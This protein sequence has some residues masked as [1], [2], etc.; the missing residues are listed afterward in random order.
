MQ[1]RVLMD[2][3]RRR[4]DRAMGRQDMMMGPRMM[5]RMPMPYPQMPYPQMSQNYM[6]DEKNPYGS[7]GGYVDSMHS[8]DGR[9]YAMGGMDRYPENNSG[10]D[11]RGRSDYRGQDYHMGYKQYGESPRHMD[12]EL[13]G[14]GKLTPMHQ[15]YAR[16]RNRDYLM[17]SHVEREYEDRENMERRMAMKQQDSSDYAGYR[18][19][20]DYNDYA[21]MDYASEEKDYKKK[22][23]HW[24]DKLK[25]KD[26]RFNISKEQV[27][28]RAKQM[29]VKFEEYDE[30]EFYFVY[31]LNIAMYSNI[32]NDSNVYIGMAK[33]WLDNEIE[34]VKGGEKVCK[35]IYEILEGEER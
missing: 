7:K 8:N 15:D 30:E 10:Q 23:E 6:Q 17:G 14:Y 31:L 22:L 1:R 27:M 12:Y 3:A 18:D 11:Y 16:G 33:K 34:E 5:G 13:Y 26:T 9:D 25:K 28:N 19:Y 24:T 21:D 2:R 29:N 32:T 35:Y 4:G 20:R